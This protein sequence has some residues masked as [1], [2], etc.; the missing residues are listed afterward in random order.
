MKRWNPRSPSGYVRSDRTRWRTIWPP[1]PS[2]RHGPP[3]EGPLCGRVT[4]T[5]SWGVGGTGWRGSWPS[6]PSAS[7][8]GVH[9]HARSGAGTRR[10]RP[11]PLVLFHGL[12]AT[13]HLGDL[14]IGFADSAASLE[15]SARRRFS[16]A[17]VA[18]R[19]RR[20]RS[21]GEATMPPDRDARRRTVI[22]APSA[23]LIPHAALIHDSASCQ[24]V[25]LVLYQPVSPPPTPELPSRRQGEAS[26]RASA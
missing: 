8:R 16:D 26:S 3:S 12:G 23:E 2:Q 17:A 10:S 13:Q 18:N 24:T 5:S 19:A 7:L 9:D 14:S 1:H 22:A 20:L 4:F 15:L 11:R 25:R 6:A 21:A